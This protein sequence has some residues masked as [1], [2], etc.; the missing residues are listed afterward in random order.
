M[1]RSAEQTNRTRTA[2]RFTRFVCSALRFISHEPRKKDTHSLNDYCYYSLTS[3]LNIKQFSFLFVIS[4][5][6]LT[7]SWATT[8]LDRYKSKLETSNVL[9][10]TIHPNLN[11]CGVNSVWSHL[12]QMYINRSVIVVNCVFRQN[13]SD[14]LILRLCKVSS[15]QIQNINDLHVR[16]IFRWTQWTFKSQIKSFI[17][18]S[19]R[20]L[21]II[22]EKG[23]D[24]SQSSDKSPNTHRIIQNATWQHKNATKNIDYTKFADRLRMVSWSDKYHTT[25]PHNWCG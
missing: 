10:G 13:K 2:S 20:I 15:N 14:E 6:F 5:C 7:S 11:C 25:G 19:P 3:K 16:P 9:P 21:Y 22:R 17:T 24:L 1:N 18:F 23:R 4:A 8:H 12:I